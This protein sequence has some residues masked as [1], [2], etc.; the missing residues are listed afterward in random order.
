M[1]ALVCA[2]AQTEPRREDGATPQA[3][4]GAADETA[5]ETLCFCHWKSPQNNA[6]KP[7]CLSILQQLTLVRSQPC[8][9][10]TNKPKHQKTTKLSSGISPALYGNALTS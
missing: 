2:G 8:S 1:A 5:G 3:G 10:Q 6:R 9:K 4:E 7:P